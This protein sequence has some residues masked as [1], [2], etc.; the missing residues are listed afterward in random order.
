MASKVLSIEVGYSFTK[1]CEL[2]YK[3]KKPK[4][5]KSFVIPTPKGVIS[6]GIIAVDDVFV[7]SF[8][9]K[10]AEMNIKTK[11]AIFTISSSKIASREVRIPYCKENRISDLVRA[12][13]ADYF[14]IDVSQYM[15]AHS[16]LEVEG[17]DKASDELEGAKSK[18]QPTGY[19]LLIL[20][21]PQQIINGYHLVSNALGLELKE[22]DYNG[23]SIYQAAKE[24]CSEG[25]Q[26]IVKID[27]RS[28]LIL[29]L[30]DGGIVL[31]RTIPYGI[32]DAVVA[33][34]ETIAWEELVDYEAALA[35]ARKRTCILPRFQMPQ[36][37]GEASAD[38]AE[39]RMAK[40]SITTSLVSL[41]GGI[42]KVV[43]YYN[44]NHSDA[45]IEKMYLT[46]VGAD[47]SGISEL[48]SNEIGFKVRNLT[49]L[50]GVNIDKAFKEVSFGEYVSCVGAA[51]AP[52]HF[53]SD[54]ED[55]KGKGRKKAK[56]K[57]DNM[58]T[59]VV[60]C[61]LC[62]VVGLIMIVISLMPYL[63]EKKKQSEYNKIIEEL[64]PVYEVYLTHQSLA[65]QANLMKELDAE[66]VNRN[67][68]IVAFITALEKNMPASF[69]LNDMTTTA[70]GIV[71]NVTVKTKEEAAV[72]LA[73]LRKMDSFIFVDT[74]ALSEVISE[75]GETQYTF[76]VE[77]LYAPIV[78]ETTEGGEE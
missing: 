39:V 12:N 29:V 70:E 4:I 45:P 73:E 2:D 14:P 66:T 53:S 37:G 43:D 26:M 50:S 31:N 67:K 56:G 41:V 68:E 48:F 47:F 57:K 13:I 17:V 63:A 25:T 1:V 75:V 36:A 59:A 60:V 10:L 78:Q 20:A 3:T 54:K 21:V 5:Y 15:I 23:N 24:E 40:I 38:T 11:A 7:G 34:S 22:I 27:E 55:Q 74:T 76:A 71:M 65:G 62:I 72:V 33:L 44:A 6:D 30:K 19:K 64:Q 46:G 42:S 32:D 77:M 9:A 52:V 8:K 58:L 16:I 51:M 69:V 49:N 35:F 18:A 61:V 28:S